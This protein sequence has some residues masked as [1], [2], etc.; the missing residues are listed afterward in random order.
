MVRVT[1]HYPRG[2]ITYM[3]GQCGANS[4]SSTTDLAQVTCGKCLELIN[5]APEGKTMYETMN[6]WQKAR[7][8]G[9]NAKEG[10][11]NPYHMGTH[12]YNCWL[13][14]YIDNQLSQ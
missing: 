7:E 8:E 6:E 4:V 14:G 2:G 13:E 5:N 10:A 1:V 9:R 11:R 12:L 3:R